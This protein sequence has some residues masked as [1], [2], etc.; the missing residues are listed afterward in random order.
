MMKSTLVSFHHVRM[1]D[2]ELVS[3]VHLAVR[4]LLSLLKKNWQNSLGFA[5]GEHL[6]R[7]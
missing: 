2:D 3:D 1:T 5:H 6:G 7:A 4:V